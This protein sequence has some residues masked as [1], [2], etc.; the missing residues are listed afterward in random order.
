MQ[1]TL[2]AFRSRTEA[3][4]YANLLFSYHVG[5]KIVNTPRNIGVSCGISVKFFS[6]YKT[7]AQEIISRRKFDTFVGFF[8]D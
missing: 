4:T 7:I 3:L 2:A 8:N 6:C 5:V 1:Y